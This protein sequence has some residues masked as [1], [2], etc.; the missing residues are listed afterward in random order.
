MPR[1][2]HTISKIRV[3]KLK[4]EIIRFSIFKIRLLNVVWTMFGTSETWQ[5]G[6]SM[7][8]TKLILYGI[9]TKMHQITGISD[10]FNQP[11]FCFPPYPD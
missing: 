4:N 7:S 2:M 3:L 1:V 10:I 8:V 5:V 9:K 11:E 6:F